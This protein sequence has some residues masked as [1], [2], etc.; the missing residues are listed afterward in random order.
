MSEHYTSPSVADILEMWD[1]MRQTQEGEI[2]Q[3][4]AFATQQWVLGWNQAVRQMA[5]AMQRQTI[6]TLDRI[7]T[8]VRQA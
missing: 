3:V 4:V 6:P 7:R 2:N 1:E 8:T 5:D